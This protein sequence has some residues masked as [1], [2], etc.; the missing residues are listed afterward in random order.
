MSGRVLR[1]T[2]LAAGEKLFSDLPTVLGVV[3][4]RNLLQKSPF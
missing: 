3:P 1:E 4:F 2:E